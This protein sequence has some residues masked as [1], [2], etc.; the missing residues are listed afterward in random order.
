M[1][2]II[3]IIGLFTS[4]LLMEFIAWFAHKYIMHGFLWKIHEDHHKPTGHIFQ[5]NDWFFL[6]F[7]VPS[8]QFI[9]LGFIFESVISIGVGFG[10]ALYGIAYFMIHEVLIHRRFNWLDNIDNRYFKAVKKAHR[11]HHKKTEKENGECF[12]LLYVPKKYWK[13]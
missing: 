6:I 7:A 5:K 3:F 10:I 8:W 2:G 4:F 11:T 9:M 1:D 12:G 13:K